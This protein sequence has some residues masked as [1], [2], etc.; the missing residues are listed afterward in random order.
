MSKAVKTLLTFGLVCM[1]MC[2]E[3]RKVG[4]SEAAPERVTSISEGRREKRKSKTKRKVIINHS[5]IKRKQDAIYRKQA[6]DLIT[7]LKD[8]FCADIY[9]SGAVEAPT[10]PLMF[11]TV[12]P[13]TTVA[14][15]TAI[16]RFHAFVTNPDLAQSPTSF[17]DGDSLD[18]GACAYG[19]HLLQLP[20]PPSASAYGHLYSG[21]SKC[22]PGQKFSRLGASLSAYGKQVPSNKGLP[23]PAWVVG[24]LTAHFLTQKTERGL[25]CAAV[26]WTLFDTLARINEL[27]EAK[28]E[29]LQ[30]VSGAC[31]GAK[32]LAT[33]AF[34]KVTNMATR[35]V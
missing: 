7:W 12:Q 18:R 13:A 6:N 14:Y 32:S 34:P 8:T 20:E 25:M 9:P 23:M 27:L 5:D 29:D 24:L 10:W 2:H 21:L 11:A 3:C 22:F 35:K 19:A 31:K 28:M 17:A 30:D 26:V 15:G 1:T 16:K 4:A 33:L